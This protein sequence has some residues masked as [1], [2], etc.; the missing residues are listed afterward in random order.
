[1]TDPEKIAEVKKT[2]AEW[3]LDGNA[4]GGAAIDVLAEIM[5]ILE[6]DPYEETATDAHHA[7]SEGRG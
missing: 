1:M 2:V 5:N 7:V 3:A 4:G 6:F